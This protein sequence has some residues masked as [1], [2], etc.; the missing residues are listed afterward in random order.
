MAGKGAQAKPLIGVTRP[1]R[2]AFFSYLCV[3]LAVTL[4][5][6]RTQRLT[7]SD[8]RKDIAVDGLIIGGGTDIF[9]TLFNHLPKKSYLYDHLR[10]E[11]EIWWE[12]RAEELKIPVLGICRG[13]QLM[14]VARGGGLHLDV[15]K[16]YKNADYPQG[17][18]RHLFF[19]KKIKIVADSLLGAA[20]GRPEAR[21]NS[22]HSQSISKQGE[23]V[24]VVAREENGVIQAIE[25]PS[26]P[27]FLG[28]QFHPEFLI[29]RA[30]C[31]RLFRRFVDAARR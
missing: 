15:R 3:W 4:A 27:F 7:P 12:R 29:Y 1:D 2:R 24:R 28:V 19:R 14:N 13:A 10:D 30:D 9:P 23:H 21:V 22:I 18:L 31:R 25:D 17:F 11:M 5:G 16:A 26:L 8:P 6:G 20:F